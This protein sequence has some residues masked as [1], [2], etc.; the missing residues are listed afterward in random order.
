MAKKKAKGSLV[1]DDTTELTGLSD[2]LNPIWDVR[3]LY[4]G[5]QGKGMPFPEQQSW[6]QEMPS[7]LCPV[8]SRPG[9]RCLVPQQLALHRLASH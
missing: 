1:L 5:L 3:A 2:G 8:L 6:R 7:P 4:Y 9:R